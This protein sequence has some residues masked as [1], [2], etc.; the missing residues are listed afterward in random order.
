MIIIYDTITN[1]IQ[2]TII[3]TLLQFNKAAMGCASSLSSFT[4]FSRQPADRD[5]GG[6]TKKRGTYSSIMT[7]DSLDTAEELMSSCLIKRRH[8]H[9]TYFRLDGYDVGLRVRV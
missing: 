6:K 3:L 5:T 1:Q 2:L 9:P 4:S 8:G 7:L